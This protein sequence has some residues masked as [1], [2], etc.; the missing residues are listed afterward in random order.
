M[1]RDEL[2]HEH[3]M[4]DIDQMSE[5]SRKKR[6]LMGTASYALGDDQISMMS[7]E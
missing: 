4:I 1:M 2:D 5:Q 3:D 6:K 7:G